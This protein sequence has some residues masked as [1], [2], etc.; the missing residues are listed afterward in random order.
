MDIDKF[1]HRFI[2]AGG[3]DFNNYD[4]MARV[5]HTYFNLLDVNP[6]SLLII[7]GMAKGADLLGR[8]I[9]MDNNLP[10]LEMP[11][12]WNKYGRSAGYRRN[13]EMAN[14]ATHLIA[15]W[16]GQSKGT[17]HMINIMSAINV[18]NTIVQIY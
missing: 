3:R 7:S 2:I 1:N 16:D 11:A 5:M 9:A 10:V 17:R 14:K 8:Q 12:E 15:F 18:H 4:K 13:T 6:T